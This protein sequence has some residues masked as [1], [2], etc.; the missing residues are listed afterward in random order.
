MLIV[1][2][3]RSVMEERKKNLSRGE[4]GEGEG[5]EAGRRDR[6]MEGKDQERGVRRREGRRGVRIGGR[7]VR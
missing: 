7:W 4:I 1:S 5:R 6:C 3:E 2:Q